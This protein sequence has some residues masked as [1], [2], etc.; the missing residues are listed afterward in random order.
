M[1]VGIDD[2]AM[3]I[4]PQV[5]GGL[6]QGD[7]ARDAASTQ[8][9]ATNRAIGEQSRQ[10]NLQRYDTQPYRNAG[11]AGLASLRQRLGLGGPTA[12]L[13]SIDE[14]DPAFKSLYDAAVNDFDQAHQ[15]RFGMSI[16]DPRA[17]ASSRD[18]QL[19]RYK[20]TVKQQVLSQR[21]QTQQPEQSPEFGD[22]NKKFSL[23]DFWNDP[24]TQAS[25]KSGLDLGTTALRNA[26]PLTTG[27]DSGA[28]LKELTKFGTDYTGQKA[29]ESYNRFTNDQG[30]AFNRL[31]ALTGIGQTAVG[32]VNA[33]G[34]N[35]GNNI[36]SLI[37]SQGNANAAARIGQAN[38]V[39]AALGSISNWWNQNQMLN[40]VLGSR[41]APT[42]GMGGI[43]TGG[44]DVSNDWRM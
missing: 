5:I 16:W 39:R 3:L 6:I 20:D 43:P 32:Q 18:A 23:S 44:W 15:Q 10:Y 17:D 12:A 35:A 29:G 42:P 2:V 30:T 36:S 34:T 11:T 40:K 33:A 19:Q 21:P 7:A 31:A 9:D 25:Y 4:G 38:A 1:A 14:N 8:A 26:A 24:V 41:G 22:I 37:S 28:A 13:D 27:L